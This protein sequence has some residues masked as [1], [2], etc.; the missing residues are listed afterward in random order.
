MANLIEDRE[1]E[2]D[3]ESLQHQVEQPKISALSEQ[4]EY[5]PPNFKDILE[6]I[7]SWSRLLMSHTFFAWRTGISDRFLDEVLLPR[8]RD[9]GI[10]TVI[11][12]LW[13]SFWLEN[14]KTQT[15]CSLETLQTHGLSSVLT[16]GE[17]LYV[18]NAQTP[19][20]G[21][22]VIEKVLRQIN[23]KSGTKNVRQFVV[24]LEI[25]GPFDTQLN[26]A[27]HLL[28]RDGLARGIVL[29]LHAEVVNT[30]K[31]FLDQFHNHIILMPSKSEIDILSEI[32]PMPIDVL[33]LKGYR[34]NVA[35]IGGD[36]LSTTPSW[37]II[38]L[39]GDS[40]IARDG[41]R[42]RLQELL[43]EYEKKRQAQVINLSQKYT[44]PRSATPDQ[45][46]VIRQIDSTIKLIQGELLSLS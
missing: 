10:A 8:L 39:S 3:K 42:K 1:Y 9:I 41:E 27:L 7:S 29:W 15:F 36:C 26:H 37:K 32:Q 45:E 5:I 13:R 46:Q 24:L 23:D 28:M 21:F 12:P 19:E 22:Q 38:R 6:S 11:V 16:S 18:F 43:K 4:I 25:F 31:G 17:F 40:E 2:T 44:D 34:R 20:D 33:E 14:L 30:P 35:I